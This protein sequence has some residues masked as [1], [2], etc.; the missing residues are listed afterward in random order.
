MIW[1]G[2]KYADKVPIKSSIAILVGFLC[3]V[4]FVFIVV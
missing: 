4:Q 3:I 1:I 2:I